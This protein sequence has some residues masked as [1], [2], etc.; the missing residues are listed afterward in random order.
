MKKHGFVKWISLLI[1][2]LF[3]LSGIM[4]FLNP[5]ITA[6]AILLYIPYMLIVVG[7]LKIIRYFMS[8]AFRVGSFLVSG[9]M[10]LLVGYLILKHMSTAALTFSILIGFWVFIGGVTEIANSIDLKNAHFDRWWL[11]LISG[12]VGLILGYMLLTNRA[13]T[14]IYV[15][16]VFAIYLLVLGTSLIALFFQIHKLEKH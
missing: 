9:I 15:S 10:D 16:T 12:I 7:I 11:G 5:L 6:S 3:I 8:D 2:V 13:L 1:G 14:A 4:T